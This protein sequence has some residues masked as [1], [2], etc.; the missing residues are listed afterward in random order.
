MPRIDLRVPFSE[1]EDAR[2][3]GARWDPRQ[4]VWYVPAGVDVAPLQKWLPAPRA[5]N[6]RAPWYYLASTLR[7]CWSCRARTRVVAFVLPA[8]HEVLYIEDDPA[9]DYWEVAGEPTLLSYVAHVGDRVA[10][11]LRTGAPHYGVD[12]S[13]TTKNFYWMNHCEHCVAKLG[14]YFTCDTR[15][16]GFAPLTSEQAAMICLTEISEPFSGS[17]GSYTLGLEWFPDAQ[18]HSPEIL[19]VV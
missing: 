13:Q 19:S 3:L 2:R 6:V 12:F 11:H 1:K 7:D 14:D 18:R 17:C 15:G 8:G 4:K 16:E 5:P 9:D 10:A